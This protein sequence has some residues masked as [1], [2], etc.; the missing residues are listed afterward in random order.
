MCSYSVLTKETMPIFYRRMHWDHL[1]LGFEGWAAFYDLTDACGDPFNS[2]DKRGR[3]LDDYAAAYRN[4]RTGQVAPSRRLE[5][6]YKGLT[7]L[8]LAKWCRD[9]I[10]AMKKK[11]V[12]VAAYERELSDIID[13]VS[14]RE[15]DASA[16]A[17]RLFALSERIANQ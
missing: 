17:Q 15:G 10:A 13:E 4:V 7:E 5:A 1:Q 8:K 2:Y 16:G 11:D 9:R 3:V 14:A 12:D 6:W